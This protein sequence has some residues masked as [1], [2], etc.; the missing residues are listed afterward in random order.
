[1]KQK[2]VIRVFMDSQQVSLTRKLFNME[3]K[4]MSDQKM[5][6]KILKTIVTVPG[7][8][9]AE[10]KGSDKCLVEVEGGDGF[11][12]INL[13]EKLRRSAC[14]AEIETVAPVKEDAKPPQAVNKPTTEGTAMTVIPI[15]WP[16]YSYM[17]V[18]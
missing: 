5:R 6:A 7:V 18:Y 3:G 11:N 9:K 2:M 4:R 17:T 1:M 10:F 14:R 15:H 16:P 8:D 13:I 12:P